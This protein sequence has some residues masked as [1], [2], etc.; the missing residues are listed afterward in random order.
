MQKDK[1]YNIL[2]EA[3]VNS[4]AVRD[5]CSGFMRYIMDHKLQWDIK[6]ITYEELKNDGI[7]NKLIKKFKAD[8]IYL[9]SKL[10]LTKISFHHIPNI[11]VFGDL[12]TKLPNRTIHVGIDNRQIASEA[13]KLLSRRGLAHF[14]YVH[15]NMEAKHTHI[16][17]ATL[18]DM[19]KSSGFDC[20][21]CQ[22]YEKANMDWSALIVNLAE[23]LKKV[24]LPCGVMA[25][26]D[27]C[28]RD[29]INACN[30]AKLRI[31]EQIQIVG[32]DNDVE[33]C[34]NVLPRLSSIEP[35]FFEAGYIAAQRMEELLMAGHTDKNT[36]CAV[37]RIVERD[38]TR[39]LSNSSRLATAAEKLIS[40]YACQGLPPSPKG[41][42]LS[43]LAKVLNVSK[44][45]LELRFATAKNEGVASA[46]RRQKL[47]E[48][49]RML[50]ETNLPIGEIA[51]RCG[52]P[53]Q[54]HLNALF[55]RTFG[56]TLRDYRA[57]HLAAIKAH[58]V[59]K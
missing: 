17:A 47:N 3:L 28:A 9:N 45:L 52:F 14:A 44:S 5:R 4:K 27:W 57:R 19:A 49:C 16:R 48:V 1:Q 51:S 40:Q 36:M 37:R 15:G 46:I 31:P 10:A 39:D 35:D 2:I 32:V 50:K 22:K 41:L 29:V 13:F 7:L 56:T 42:T 8:G 24:P 6:F 59:Q 26:N 54:T 55:R 30:Y 11:V 33:I 58:S 43:C 12:N 21:E 23:E 38:T 34:E 25:Y 53:V 18:I 20:I